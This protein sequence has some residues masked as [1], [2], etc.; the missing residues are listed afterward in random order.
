MVQGLR[1]LRTRQDSSFLFYFSFPLIRGREN[2]GEKG[3]VKPRPCTLTGGFRPL[4]FHSFFPFPLPNKGGNNSD[5]RSVV[6]PGWVL[7]PQTSPP[8]FPLLGVRAVHISPGGAK[9]K[10]PLPAPLSSESR[11]SSRFPFF[12]FSFL[13]LPLIP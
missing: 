1:L 12:S 4:R 5:V 10:V 7:Y 8:F 3:R 9:N 2:R 13:P 6:T 11:P